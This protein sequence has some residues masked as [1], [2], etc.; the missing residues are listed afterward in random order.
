MKKWITL[1]DTYQIW[2]LARMEADWWAIPG[3][4]HIELRTAID[5]VKAIKHLAHGYRITH[6][7]YPVYLMLAGREITLKPSWSAR[8]RH[9]NRPLILF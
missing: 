8:A 4:A 6:N 7:G 2:R 1:P 5:S 3:A 9:E